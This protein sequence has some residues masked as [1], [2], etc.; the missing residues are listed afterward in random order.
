[1]TTTAGSDEEQ[2]VA[3]LVLQEDYAKNPNQVARLSS[4]RILFIKRKEFAL[5]PFELIE[6]PTSACSS[7]SYEQKFALARM[8]AGVALV[9]LV[10]TFF[11]MGE[12]E[13]GT[14]VPVGLP[15]I[16]VG[17]GLSLGLWVERHRPVF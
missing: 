15:G 9:V 1:M 17:V 12:V 7:I 13:A 6:L 10:I 8:I 3:T 4:Q 14:D 5:K 16:G 2:S 11:V